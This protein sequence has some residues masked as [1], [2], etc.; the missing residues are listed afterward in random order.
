MARARA[1]GR[2]EGKQPKLPLAARKRSTAGHH[3]P[4]NKVSLADL[5]QGIQRRPL[6]DPPHHLRSRMPGVALMYLVTRSLP[7]LLQGVVAQPPS[8]RRTRQVAPWERDSAIVVAHMTTTA[9]E[10]MTKPTVPVRNRSSSTV[11]PRNAAARGSAIM[12]AG[13]DAGSGPA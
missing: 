3:D 6:H 5:A 9:S 10:V 8:A 13:S 4:D 2:V 7:V 1:K 11:R 12:T